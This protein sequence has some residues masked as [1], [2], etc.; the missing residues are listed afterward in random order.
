MKPIRSPDNAHFR[1][2]LRLAGTPR[3]VRD[4]AQTLA[5]GLHLAQAALAAAVPVEALL[6]RRDAAHP[7]LAAV[8]G[9]LPATVPRY[10]CLL[11][12]SDAADE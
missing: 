8:L 5:E 6:L 9:Q 11:Y 12:T 2:W 7:E 10:D 3:A 4:S 1:H